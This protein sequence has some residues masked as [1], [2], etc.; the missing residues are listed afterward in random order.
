MK[1]IPDELAAKLDTIADDF[2]AD[3]PAGRMDA[4]AKA[5]DVPRATLYYHFSGRDDLV[6]Y[7]M[8]DKMARVEA[9][10]QEA[11]SSA[12]APLDRFAAALRAAALELA[13]KPAVCL[14]IMVAMG[15]AGAMDELMIASDQRILAPLRNALAEA[16]AA[17]GLAV[18]DLEV[19]VA[20]IM[21]GIYMAVVQQHARGVDI[22]A[23]ALADTIVA[24]ALDG[25]RHR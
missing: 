23:Q 9:V 15:R 3:G 17:D 18:T 8:S 16:T 24:Q 6:T 5:I 25:V 20:A 7:F 4:V 10:V 1:R 2:L 11:L 22:D 13:T 19:A 21:G 14:N 12:D